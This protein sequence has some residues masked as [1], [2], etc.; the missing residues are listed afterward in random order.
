MYMYVQSMLVSLLFITVTLL[1]YMKQATSRLIRLGTLYVSHTS[2]HVRPS[3]KS[4]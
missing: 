4:I 3:G 2:L 1:M